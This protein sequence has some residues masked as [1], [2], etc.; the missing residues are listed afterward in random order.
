MDTRKE[1]YSYLLKMPKKIA[2]QVKE[3]ASDQ[4]RSMAMYIQIAIQE[5]LDKDS[6]K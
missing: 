1:K 2:N 5:K 6:K 4:K 3:M